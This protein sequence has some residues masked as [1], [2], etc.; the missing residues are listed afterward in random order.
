[1]RKKIDYKKSQ[2][3]L[4]KKQPTKLVNRDNLGYLSKLVNHVNL[5]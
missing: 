2:V 5:I 1:M 3:Q 4:K